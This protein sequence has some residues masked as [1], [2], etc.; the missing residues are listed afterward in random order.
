[1]PC[2]THWKRDGVVKRL[3]GS[4]SAAQLLHAIVDT[5]AD[6]RFDEIRYVI[7]DCLDCA[8]FVFHPTEIQEMAAIGKAGA[9]SNPHIRVAVVATLPA[10]IAGA[11]QYALS[12]LNAF[13]MRIFDTREDAERWIHA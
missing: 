4:V 5:Q 1:M 7:A 8:D 6:P 12:P 2:E 3:T 10:A 13:P 11:T 9:I